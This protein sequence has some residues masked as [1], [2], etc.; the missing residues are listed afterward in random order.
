MKIKQIQK[1]HQQHHDQA[2]CGVVCL[3]SILN[4]YNSDA[5]LEKLRA[6]SGTYKTGKTLLGLMQCANKIGFTAE[7]LKLILLV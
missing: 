1:T 3:K 2:D 4:F 6:L 5:P 7:G